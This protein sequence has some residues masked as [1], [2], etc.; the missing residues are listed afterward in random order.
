[1]LPESSI[2]TMTSNESHVRYIQTHAIMQ[3]KALCPI[4]DSDTC[5]HIS[6]M[7]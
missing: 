4:D 3:L 1:M 5:K 6:V 7:K 2:T